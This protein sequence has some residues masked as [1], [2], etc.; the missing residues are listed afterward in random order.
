MDCDHESKLNDYWTRYILNKEPIPADL[1]EIRIEILDSWRRSLQYAISPFEAK[2]PVLS[3]KQLNDILQSNHLL[4]SVAHPYIENLYSYV[5]GT[6]FA[7]VL[8]DQ[9]GCIIDLISNDVYI[10]RLR[11]QSG[12]RIGAVRNE[13][14][15]GTTSIGLCLYLKAPC[16]VCGAEHYLQAH[17]IYR[18]CAAPI[19]GTDGQIIGCLSMIGPKDTPGG[20]TLGMVGAAADAIRKELQMRSSYEKIEYINSQLRTTLE[21]LSNGIIMVD[22]NCIVTQHNSRA[23]SIL[24]LKNF[25]PLG[26]PIPE[27]MRCEDP[28]LDLCQLPDNVNHQELRV[29]NPLGATIDIS[30]SAKSVFTDTGEKLG[31]IFSIDKLHN[32]HK[33]VT[34]LGGFTARYTFDSI[35]G[36]SDKLLQAKKLGVIAAESQSNLLIL[37]ESG[38]GKELFAQSVHNAG[39]HA[40]GPFVAINCASLPKS[41]I[42]SELF[43]YE[44]GAF[45]GANRDGSPGKFELADSGTIFLDEIGDMPLELQ[46]ALL[47]VL[48]TREIV[49]IGGKQPKKINVRVIAATNVN[50]LRSVQENTFRQD[51]YYRLNVL[52]IQL[53]PLRECR[54]DILPLIYHFT[55]RYNSALG[56]HCVYDQET[57]RI[58]QNYDWPGNVRELENVIERTVNLAQKENISKNELPSEILA[59]SAPAPIPAIE[60]AQTSFSP[61]SSLS[62]SPV[63]E[64]NQ[65]VEALLQEHG[66]IRGVSELLGIPKR[67]LYRKIKKYNIDLGQYRVW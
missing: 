18:G 62:K 48:Q 52:T 60:R 9:T 66:D 35:I 58:L 6:D 25:S 32:V 3:R 67:T 39:P 41:L 63:R 23:I 49:R 29:T 16:M 34:R 5:Q 27:V 20:H 38:T 37:G 14:H 22:S 31:T 2:P 36:S 7:I 28:A 17:H 11:E 45:T 12:L 40:N 50:L 55:E 24:Q 53:P 56:K 57:L 8:T 19:Y 26:M 44:R 1:P 13:R 33:L 42:E 54:E 64:Y 15:A 4:I 61:S 43:G 21:S 51:L 65:I 59:Q 47:R 10:N 30:L 46:A